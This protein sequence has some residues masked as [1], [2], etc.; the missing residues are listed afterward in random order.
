METI[1]VTNQQLSEPSIKNRIA[2][3]VYLQQCK[4]IKKQL[5][6]LEKEY[7]YRF[8]TMAS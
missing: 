3:Y 5:E 6:K 1:K 2:Y 8:N 4:K 7:A